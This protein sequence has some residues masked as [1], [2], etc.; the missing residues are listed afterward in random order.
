[1]VMQLRQKA[2]AAFDG[3]RGTLQGFD[4]LG[5]PCL[6]LRQDAGGQPLCDGVP[7]KRGSY[8]FQGLLYVGLPLTAPGATHLVIPIDQRQEALVHSLLPSGR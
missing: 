4:S 6:P 5:C 2:V 1:M 8:C 7:V 3:R